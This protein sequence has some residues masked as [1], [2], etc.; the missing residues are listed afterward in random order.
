MERLMYIAC[1]TRHL[2]CRAVCC[3]AAAH[4][5]FAG[6]CYHTV[7]LNTSTSAV[8]N[9]SEPVKNAFASTRGWPGGSSYDSR[10]VELVTPISVNCPKSIS[11]SPKFG[12]CQASSKRASSVRP[13]R[14]ASLTGPAP[15]GRCNEKMNASAHATKLFCEAQDVLVNPPKT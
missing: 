7:T 9:I 3:A 12:P 2:R 14:S 5:V 4:C 11:V 8:R 10:L 1:C 6:A 13:A 15:P